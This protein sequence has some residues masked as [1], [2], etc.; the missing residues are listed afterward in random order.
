RYVLFESDASD[1]V[2]GDTNGVSDVFM[3]DV[4]GGTTLLISVAANGGSGNGP[5]TNAVMTPDGRYVVF[6]SAATNLV[7]GD[8]NRIADLFVRDLLTQT[9]LLASVGAVIPA[10][11]TTASLSSVAIT[12]DGLYVAFASTAAGLAAEVTNRPIGE[13]YVRDL[14]TRRTIW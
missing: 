13:V 10:G 4:L 6:V 7:V 5:S 2:P 8:T 12:P 11:A 14:V 1:L 9:T 3:R